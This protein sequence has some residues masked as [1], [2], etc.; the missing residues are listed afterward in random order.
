MRM[1]LISFLCCYNLVAIADVQQSEA[2]DWR[3]TAQSII[4]A[5]DYVA[6]DYPEAVQGGEITNA[7]EYAEQRDFLITVNDLL[8]TLPAHDKQQTLLTQAQDLAALVEQRASSASVALASR[9]LVADLIDAYDIVTAPVTAPEPASVV[10]VYAEQCSVCHGASG[11][12][13]GPGGATLVPAPTDFHDADRASQR[14]L[15][16]LYSTITVGVSGTG[17]PSFVSLTEDQRWALAFYVAGF[18]D[19][20]VSIAEGE[21]DWNKG[22]VRKAFG[23]LASFTSYTP[24]T[25]LAKQHVT[26]ELLAYLRHHP[27]ALIEASA[28]PI[29]HTIDGLQNV[30]SAYRNGETDA[31]MQFAL[32][33]YLEGYELVEAPLRTLDRKLTGGIERDMQE[34]RNSIRSSVPADELTLKVAD[35]EARLQ[36]A[37]GLLADSGSSTATL[38][39]SAFLILLREGLEAILL[40]AAMSLY[41]RRTGSTSAMRYLHFGWIAALAAGGLSWI[42]IKTVISISGAQREVVEGFGA[43]LAAFV[44]L[45][46]GIW[47][48]RHSTAR[49]WQAFLNARLGK[50][51]STGTLWGIAALAFVAV[52]REILETVLFYETLW[53]QSGAAMPLVLGAS[54]AG[55]ALLVCAWLVIRIGARLPLQRFFQINGVFMF[56]LSLVFAGKGVSALQEAGWIGATYVAAPRIDWLGIYPTAQSLGSQILIVCCAAI[57]LLFQRWRE[58]TPMQQGA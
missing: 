48:H 34:L 29:A 19:D 1:I 54:L 58:S 37:S 28:D 13:D 35:L 39:L 53:L 42:G 12:G 43:L 11:R 51:L 17:M 14:S 40:L 56:V 18:G 7:D 31:A 6:I 25:L 55:V 26:G 8:A 22:D 33:A 50:H 30:L 16:G 38:L 2:P 23:T 24:A 15:Y 5:L 10:S 20:P 36:E 47:L 52:Y 41:L 49:H 45:Y 3:S 57:W 9:K 27:E 32:S 44:L 21:Q 46:V 4:G